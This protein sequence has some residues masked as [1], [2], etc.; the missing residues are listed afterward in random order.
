MRDIS[1]IIESEHT[2]GKWHRLAATAAALAAALS[3]SGCATGVKNTSR[4][5]QTVVIDAGHGGHDSGARARSGM[6]EKEAALDVAQRLEPKLRAA[7]FQTKMT[8]KS[9]VFI[10]LDRRVRASNG[11]SN[12]IFV[13]IHFNH[14][15]S[16]GISGAEVYYKS[17]VSRDIATRVLDR[18]DELPGT[19]R[20]GVKTANFRVLRLNRYPAVLVECGFMSNPTEAARSASPVHR[21]RLADAIA[22]ALV[23]QRFGA[24]GLA[25]LRPKT[26]PEAPPFQLA[27]TATPAPSPRAA[28]AP[29]PPSGRRAL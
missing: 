4:T 25:K 7:G 11:A 26:S 1:P 3:L 16:R 19:V 15:K 14:A 12:S 5:F 20:R 13:S 10:P 8:R 23:E 17:S 21:E 27:N 6:K 2:I 24:A 9:D 29:R 18:I 28:S 22:D